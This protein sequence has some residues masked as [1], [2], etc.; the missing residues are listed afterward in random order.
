MMFSR[1]RIASA[2]CNLAAG[3]RNY[4]ASF[5]TLETK[6]QT[7]FSE[8][9]SALQQRWKSRNR[10]KALSVVHSESLQRRFSG[11][12]SY[13]MRLP[14]DLGG[15]PQI[16]GSV[17]VGAIELE[18]WERECHALFA[19]LASKGFVGTDELRRSIENLTPLQYAK[20]GYY[21]KW[22]AAMVTLLLDK[23]ILKDEK[24]RVAL[25]GE[26]SNNNNSN[27]NNSQDS[28]FQSGDMVRVKSYQQGVEW[29][30]PHIR[31][32]GYVYGV[33]GRV[34]DVCGIFGDPSF[35]AFGIECPDI[36]LYRVEISM[37]DL[38]PEQSS[39]K[40]TLSVE[41]YEHWLEPSNSDKGHDFP[42]AALLN[43]DDDGRDCS[44]H[45]HHHHHDDEDHSHDPRP[46][47]ERRAA[48]KEG[49]PRPGKELFR[50]LFQ[51]V[52]EQSLVTTEEI[53]SMI[54]YLDS[55]GTNLLGRDLIVRAWKDPE[56][57]ERLLDD[58]ASAAL[59]LGIQTANPNAPT[60]LTVVQNTPKE[61][62]L[63]VCTLCSCYP[64]GLLGIAPSWYKS[65]EFRAR[66]VRE[67][68][69]VLEEFGTSLPPGQSIRV[70]DSTADHRYLVLPQRPKGTE[71]WS[72]EDL[73]ELV[74]RD[75]M[76]GASV[77]PYLL[78]KVD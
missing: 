27:N 37:Q 55:A 17:P 51:V 4:Y 71:N 45:H 28:L 14:H 67:P 76:I 68:R 20:W 6:I 66:A 16:L 56:F 47:V 39:S 22:T 12:A 10:A 23:G 2:C 31:T 75:S 65:S 58:A 59:E 33:N 72:E 5:Q 43:H 40:D 18:V 53:R 74:T 44:D 8:R 64:S 29:R 3:R 62:N 54:E 30:R 63:V 69:E 35:L 42:E 57:A 41:I 9:K 70:H 49:P 52:L 61:H 50:A 36:Y 21:E 38:W 25:F 11:Q 78:E 32:P 73:K 24:L 15:S 19:V 13:D 77:L 26:T 46:L 1:T 60:V 34:V 48:E 7:P